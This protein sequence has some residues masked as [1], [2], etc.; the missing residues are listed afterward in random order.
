MWREL[1]LIPVVFLF[2]WFPFGF[3]RSIVVIG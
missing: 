2:P 1:Q 3:L